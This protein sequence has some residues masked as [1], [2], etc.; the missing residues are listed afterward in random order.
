MKYAANNK[1]GP[2]MVIG[3][4]G[5]LGK[6]LSSHLKEAGYEVAALGHDEI[7][8]TGS[9]SIDRAL[10]RWNPEIVINCA[11]ISSTTYAAE[12]PEESMRI[13]V[14]ACENLAKACAVSDRR[15]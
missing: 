7:D 1:L 8:I 5:F 4:C 11:A 13:N 10:S 14:N 12:H 6:H 2:V 15:L 9:S 3:A